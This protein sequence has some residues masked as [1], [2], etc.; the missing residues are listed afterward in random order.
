MLY[1]LD[2]FLSFYAEPPSIPIADGPYSYYL[3]IRWMFIFFDF[4]RPPPA[5]YFD[6]LFISFF[7]QNIGFLKSM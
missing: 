3:K 4:E 2:A 5:P 7:N 1:D 6:P